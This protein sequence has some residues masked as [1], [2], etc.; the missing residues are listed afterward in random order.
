MKTKYL[1]AFMVGT[2]AAAAG[3]NCAPVD[4]ST[5]EE[6]KSEPRVT[7]TERAP[8]LRPDDD[9]AKRPDPLKGRLDAAIA[10]ARGRDL[11]TDNGFWTIFHG[12]LGLGPTVQLLDPTTGKRVNAL[13]YIAGG[14][15]VRGMRFNPGPDGIDVETRPGTFIFQ[16]HSD[17]FVA[18]MV[19]WDVSPQRKFVVNGKDYTFQDFI[20]NTRARASARSS[21]ELEWA[22]VVI[23]QHYSL[24]SSWTNAAGE[25]V[26][27]EDLLRHE[28][29]RPLDAAACGGTHLLFGLTW[30]Y[31]LHRQHGGRT[32][33]VWKDVADRI[34]QYKKRARELQNP[35]GSFST[36]FFRDAASA[37]DLQL[38]MNTTGHIFEW[39][40]LALSDDELKEPWVR[41]AANAVAMML[42]EI[43][44]KPMEGGTMYHAVHGLLIYSGRAYGSEGLG[45]RAPHV[46]PPPAKQR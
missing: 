21:S 7:S 44:G 28:L 35:D 9:L 17:Q 36:N 32:E 22:L 37:P 1:I 2:A 20:G 3:I 24:D 27:F 23:G 19:Q 30:V 8:P 31:H 41:D 6:E 43:Q 45:P 18:E 25:P 16:G 26:R 46:P 15:A 12:I 39:L 14:G 11:R 13:D 42:L 4:T 38:R 5:H 40:A 34:E 33:G 29:D 10:E